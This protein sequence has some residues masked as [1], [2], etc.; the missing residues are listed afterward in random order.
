MKKFLIFGAGAVG[1]YVGGFLAH[2]GH[3]VTLVTRS[4][5]EALQQQGLTIIRSSGERIHVRPA[6]AATLRQGLVLAEESGQPYDYLVLAMKS[7]DLPAAINEMVAFCPDPPTVVTLQN[8]INVELP[9]VQQFGAEKLI[10]GSL[11]TPVSYDSNLNLVEERGDRGVAFA[12]LTGKNNRAHQALASLVDGTGLQAV[13]IKNYQSLKWSKALINMVGNATAAIVNRPPGVL[14]RY[15][16][17]YELELRMLR[18]ALL[19]MKTKKI[20]IIDLPGSPVRRLQYAVNRLPDFLRYPLLKRVV[21]G[22]RGSKMPSFQI[23]LAAGKSKNEVLYHN[24]AVFRVAREVGV[25]APVNA[26]LT[27]ILLQIARREIDWER[28][29]G[30]PRLLLEA[31]NDHIRQHR[32]GAT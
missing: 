24:G 4:G 18:E 21:A 31:V 26:A 5:A 15:R 1:S 27:D 3:D 25:P 11:T 8:G 10:A 17:L 9:L 29:N 30:K 6:V 32:E 19:V 13:P 2:G 23:D 28:F 20:P 7:Y 12:T 14:Y 16:P 22:G